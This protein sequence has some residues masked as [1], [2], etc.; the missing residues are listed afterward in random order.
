M[1]H[2]TDMS[3]HRSLD[4]QSVLVTAVVIVVYIVFNR[5]N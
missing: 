4:E 5:G 3:L 2:G 1:I